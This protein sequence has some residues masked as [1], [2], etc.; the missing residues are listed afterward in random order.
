[1]PPLRFLAAIAF[2]L[3]PHGASAQHNARVSLDWPGAYRAAP[4]AGCA[5]R[6]VWLSLE[7]LARHARYELVEAG[8]RHRG[9]ARWR[10]D[11]TRLDL[12]GMTPPRAVFVTE[13]AV[14][15]GDARA[16]PDRG[17]TLTKQETFRNAAER[18]HVDPAS[19]RVEKGVARFRGL[20][21]LAGRAPGGHL[22]LDAAFV[23]DCRARRMHMPQVAY[24]AGRFGSGRL[25][26]EE[27]ANDNPPL[28]FA[29][30]RDVVARAAARYCPSR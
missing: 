17:Q 7:A 5:G 18:L 25:I 12:V 28:R 21:T 19:L 13:N 23:I 11:G 16:D 27:K 3:L 10:P 1:M 26:H 20:W 30:P 14:I 24:Y 22:S 15:L 8:E 9:A 2:A 29:G 4:C 6:G